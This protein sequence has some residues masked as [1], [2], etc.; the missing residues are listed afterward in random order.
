MVSDMD[1][2]V[3]LQLELYCILVKKSLTQPDFSSTNFLSSFTT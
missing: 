3:I 2:N 1:F